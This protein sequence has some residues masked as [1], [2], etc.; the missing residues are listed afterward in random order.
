MNNLKLEDLKVGIM[1]S[2]GMVGGALKRYFAKVGRKIFV[3]DKYKNEGSLEEVNQADVVFVC[4]PTPY[5]EAKGG[6]DL[7]F[8]LAALESLTGEKIVVIKSTVLPGTTLKLQA[9][10]RQH[11]FIF[12]P[13]FLT[14]SSADND[15]CFPDR[16]IIG[17][18]KESYNAAGIIMR[19]LPLAP[20]ERIVPATE[21]EMIKYF[22]NTWFTT[23]VIFA[24]Q[25]YDM[26]QKLGVDYDVVKECAA[27]DKRI[28]PSHLEIF[29]GGYRGYG[30]AC[31]PKDTMALIQL[32]DELG[33]PME[34]LKI[35]AEVNKK[36]AANQTGAAP[37]AVHLPRTTDNKAVAPNLVEL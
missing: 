27:A 24:N 23:K 2:S 3:F 14:Q 5:D 28:G 36:L 29:H 15:M 4:V 10:F 19:L 20:F 8:V 21:A 26:C 25:M 32:G 35:A 34:L 6:F 33:A 18:T 1:G 13:E 22:G 7:S 12:N 31:L 17:Y 37:E 9:R 16:Q 30:G 11:K